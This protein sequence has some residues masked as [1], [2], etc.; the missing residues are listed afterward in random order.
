MHLEGAICSWKRCGICLQSRD[1]IE[2]DLLS[3]C[4]LAPSRPGIYLVVWS[5]SRIG[6]WIVAF[7][8]QRKID[9]VVLALAA[10]TKPSSLNPW[11]DDSNKLTERRRIQGDDALGTTA[12]GIL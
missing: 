6:D 3:T 4:G 12:V 11:K 8:V 9:V 5:V 2:V 7:I 10:H 1:I